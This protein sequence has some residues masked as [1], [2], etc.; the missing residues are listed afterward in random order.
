MSAVRWS[1]VMLGTG[2]SLSLL[3]AGI[4]SVHHHTGPHL[5]TALTQLTPEA[6]FHVWWPGGPKGARVPQLLGDL[7]SVSLPQ[8]PANA[9]A[10][11]GFEDAA[12]LVIRVPKGQLR[13]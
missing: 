4:A 10:K 8:P 12:C 7:P 13:L 5:V 1:W 6:M 9:T 11:Q 3:S 2:S